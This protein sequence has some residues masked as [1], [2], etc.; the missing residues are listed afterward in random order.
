MLQVTPRA[1]AVLQD[2]RAH[3]GLPD[4]FGLRVRRDRSG[5]TGASGSTSPTH[6]VEG[7]EI[8]EAAVV[9][10]LGVGRNARRI[11]VA[12]TFALDLY[13]LDEPVAVNAPPADQ[14]F[15]FTR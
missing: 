11:A 7:D 13:P 10:R 15:D 1:A 5:S 14:I 9:R 6:P 4:A 3:R 2:E 12:G 8:T